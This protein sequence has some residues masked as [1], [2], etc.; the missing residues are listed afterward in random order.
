M[1][2]GSALVA[3]AS[4]VYWVLAVTGLP[5][6]QAPAANAMA[7]PDA[8]SAKALA[9]ALGGDLQAPA[10]SPALPSTQYQLAGVVAGPVGKGYALLAVGSAPAKAYTVGAALPDGMVLQ[11]VSARGAHIGATVQGPTSL[12]LA[13]PKPHGW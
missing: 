5:N 13:L 4:V 7:A 11:S 1:S 12:E 3:G 2:F 6:Q 9:R 8:V 10:S